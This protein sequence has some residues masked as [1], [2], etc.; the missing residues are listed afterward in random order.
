MNTVMTK[1]SCLHELFEMQA[2]IRPEHPA[3]ICREE[4]LSYG[5]VERRANQLARH[6]RDHDVGPGSLVALY[7][8][9]SEKPIISV[10]ATLKA[11]AG[12]V[13]IDPSFPKDRMRHILD[14]SGA[15]V[16]VSESVLSGG[17]PDT[18]DGSVVL[19]DDQAMEI[20]AHSS[21]RLSMEE[22]QVT[23]DDLTYVLY[24]S[25][26]TGRPKGVMPEHRNVVEFVSSFN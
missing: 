5:H 2:D 15:S 25:G 24:T 26:T 20:A 14:E 19:I 13:P 10:L 1:L 17:I 3:L 23:P 16:I 7:F 22:T 4:R 8:E 21:E 9:R 18:F 6:L 12:Y 11:G